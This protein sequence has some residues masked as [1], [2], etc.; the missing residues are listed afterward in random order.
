MC[1]NVPAGRLATNCQSPSSP[2]LLRSELQPLSHVEPP[3]PHGQQRRSS[4]VSVYRRL[5][6]QP[7]HD[8]EG[9][10]EGVLQIRTAGEGPGCPR[11][12]GE[13]AR[14]D[15]VAEELQVNLCVSVILT[16]FCFD[17]LDGPAASLLSTSSRSK[18]PRRPRRPCATR[19][20]TDDASEWTS[21]SL[22]DRTRP[23]PESTWADPRSKC[24]SARISWRTFISMMH[25]FY[26]IMSL[27]S[28]FLL[29][30]TTEKALLQ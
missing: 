2:L 8:G 15:G 20:S 17:R 11:R 5:R 23:P 1:E 27:S 4:G 12:Q 7:I 25:L 26:R 28:D 29:V 18:T 3:A 22:R 16:I 10:G 13:R 24:D 6:A 30:T 21:P 9:A 14:N 19:R